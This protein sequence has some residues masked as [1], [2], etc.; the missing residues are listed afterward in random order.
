MS[1]KEH[2]WN[3]V[4]L[5]GREINIDTTF[6]DESVEDRDYYDDF[7]SDD[8]HIANNEPVLDYVKDEDVG[9]VAS[10]YKPSFTADKYIDF[11][12]LQILVN[13]YQDKIFL[14]LFAYMTY[15]LVEIKRNK[16]RK[17]RIKKRRRSL[18]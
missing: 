4:I 6:M 13:N 8:V 12:T 11:T 14:V 3:K 17:K 16:N 10:E 18:H 1:N 7:V 9:Y 5:D 15:N 2:A